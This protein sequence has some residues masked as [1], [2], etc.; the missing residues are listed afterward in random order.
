[1]H[2]SWLNQEQISLRNRN[3]FKINHATSPAFFNQSNNVIVILMS[4]RD[5]G[6]IVLCGNDSANANAEF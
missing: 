1:M 6:I 4:I 3:I 2:L 5:W